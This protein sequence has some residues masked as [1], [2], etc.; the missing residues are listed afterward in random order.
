MGKPQAIERHAIEDVEGV[1]EMKLTASQ[2]EY[3]E[4]VEGISRAGCRASKGSPKWKLTSKKTS[5]YSMVNCRDCKSFMKCAEEWH[6]KEWTGE[7]GA[8]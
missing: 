1:L 5:G 6:S 3:D 4:W 7:E 8:V 2:K